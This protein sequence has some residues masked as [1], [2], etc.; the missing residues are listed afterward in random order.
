MPNNG[1]LIEFYLSTNGSSGTPQPV[2]NDSR[3]NNRSSTKLEHVQSTA[4]STMTTKEK[5]VDAARAGDDPADYD[6]AWLLWVTGGQCGTCRKIA[7]FDEP[8]RTF[9][10]ELPFAGL[11]QSGDYYRVYQPLALFDDVSATRCGSGTDDYRMIY[12]L[13]NTGNALTNASR[14]YGL[15]R[16]DAADLE[17]VASG[18]DGEGSEYTADIYTAPTLIYPFDSGSYEPRWGNPRS[19]SAGY[20][21]PG[22]N[23]N[24]ANSVR[25]AMW[26]RRLVD[27]AALKA[28]EQ[29]WQLFIA[30]DEGGGDPDPLYSSVLIVASSAGFTPAITISE[31]R[32]IRIGG[33][34]RVTA[35]VDADPPGVPAAD[36]PV[37]WSHTGP[38]TLYHPDEPFTDD[39]G[40]AVAVYHSPT[41]QAEAGNPVTFEATV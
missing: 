33:G 20:S 2:P 38:G 37:K 22:R 15:V 5:M 30:F 34:C 31:D 26:I 32:A 8:T 21:Q 10:F 39:G 36:V 11:A 29:V 19:Q 28:G 12:V 35:Q 9:T 24:W 17:L 18:L 13:N 6:G 40:E 14:W 27:P 1:N 16:G 3:G 41:D 4:T 7:D 25:K 23:D